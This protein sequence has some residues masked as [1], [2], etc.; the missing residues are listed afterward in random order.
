MEG[1]HSSRSVV[2]Y[3][4][5]EGSVVEGVPCPR[6]CFVVKCRVDVVLEV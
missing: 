3:N 6:Y 2:Y 1:G 5:V 4:V